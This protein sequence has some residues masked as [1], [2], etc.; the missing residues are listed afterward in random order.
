MVFEGL[1]P[2]LGEALFRVWGLGFSCLGF[3][4]SG[5]ELQDVGLVGLYNRKGL[6]FRV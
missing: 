2:F 3:G 6:G 5:L 1:P 4:V